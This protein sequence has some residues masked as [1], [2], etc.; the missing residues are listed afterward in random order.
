MGVRA[1]R[2]QRR[3]TEVV[4]D[5]EVHQTKIIVDT[6]PLLRVLLPLADGDRRLGG[7]VRVAK[8]VVGV[9]TWVAVGGQILVNDARRDGQL[10][11][12]LP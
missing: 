11:R 12:R 2:G 8:N 4:I 10:F 9:L 5:L 6:F 3:G 1:D 7:L